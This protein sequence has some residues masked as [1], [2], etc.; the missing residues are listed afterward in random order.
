MEA[1]WVM[2]ACLGVLGLAV[3]QALWRRLN[4]NPVRRRTKT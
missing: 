3:M 2:Q 4:R 1:I